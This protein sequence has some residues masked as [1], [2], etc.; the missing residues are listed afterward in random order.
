MSNPNSQGSLASQEHSQFDEVEEKSSL[1]FFGTDLAQ[2]RCFKPAQMYGVGAG[3][4]AGIVYNLAT[5]RPPWK[6]SWLTYMAVTSVSFI[7]C[8][9]DHQINQQ[10]FRMAQAAMNDY[11]LIKDTKLGQELDKKWAADALNKKTNVRDFK[12]DA[13]TEQDSPGLIRWPPL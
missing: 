5:S 13:Q 7:A 12:E 3:C 6:L 4:A 10:Q 11:N 9:I 8:R 2:I 1:N